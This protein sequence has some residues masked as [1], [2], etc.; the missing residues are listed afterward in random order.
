MN[1][2]RLVGALGLALILGASGCSQ[3]GDAASSSPQNQDSG[4]VATASA[5]MPSPFDGDPVHI[6]IVQ[7]TGQGDYF[8]QY[9]NGTRLQAEALNMELDVYDAQGDNATQASQLD[10]AIAS[11]AQGIIVRHGFADTLCPGV[12]KALEAG[13]SVVI[14]DVEIQ[15][16]AP[17]AVQT[18]QSDAVMASLVLDQ[19]LADVGPDQDVGYVNVAGIAPLDRRDVVWQQYTADNNWNVLF[20][21]GKYTTSSAT[22][23]APMVDNALKANPDISAIYA[24]YD[25]LTKGTLSAL[26]QN[27][28]L[29]GKV[30]V[31]GA[32]ISTADIELMIADNSPWVAT[33]ATD[34][35]AIGAAVTRTL[36]LDMAGQLDTLNVEFPPILVTQDMLREKNIKNMDDLRA[37]EPDLNISSESSADWIPVVTF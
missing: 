10:Q 20:K 34:P 12:N 24:P 1:K 18:Q 14:Y 35:N 30:K 16:C 7:N 3:G 5:P 17:D 23:S 9:L 36:A 8:Q 28:D 32:D 11:G 25:E 29:A 15:T 21:T 19:M 26:E 13:I 33:G 31:Y 27:P 22:D 4:S 37:A 6:A 2:P